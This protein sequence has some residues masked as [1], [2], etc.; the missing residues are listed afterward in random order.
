MSLTVEIIS[1][2]INQKKELEETERIFSDFFND[3]TISISDDVEDNFMQE[4]TLK[5][6]ELFTVISL[7]DNP[8]LNLSVAQPNK[9]RVEKSVFGKGVMCYTR[10]A[11]GVLKK[12][13]TKDEKIIKIVIEVE[14]NDILNLC[15]IKDKQYLRDVYNT[16]EEKDTIKSDGDFIDYVCSNGVRNYK[17]V[18]GFIALGKRLFSDSIITDY[19]GTG[20]L[21]KKRNIIISAEEI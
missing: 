9:Y 5:R 20:F 10:G 13:L 6:I 1:K 21:L 3:A 14:T 2:I 19:M 12:Q 8:T 11:L 4:Q 7:T 15:S 17:V 18:T 16:I